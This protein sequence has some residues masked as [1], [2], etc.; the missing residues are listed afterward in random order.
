MRFKFFLVSVAL[1]AVGV[2]L[3]RMPHRQFGRSPKP[4]S[5]FGP[6]THG[7]PAGR[8]REVRTGVPGT[9]KDGLADYNVPDPLAGSGI[10]TRDEAA[11]RIYELL[12]GGG[13]ALPISHEDFIARAK[14]KLV[15]QNDEEYETEWGLFLEGVCFVA[16]TGRGCLP[17]KILYYGK[18]TEFPEIRGLPEEE[19]K[20]ALM[21]KIRVG[22]EEAI[23]L[24]ER[25]ISLRWPAFRAADFEAP[26]VS[27]GT[28]Y[29]KVT[30]DI[31]WKHVPFKSGAPNPTRLEVDVD[32]VTGQ[33]LE[34]E[35]KYLELDAEPI[36]QIDDSVAVDIARRKALEWVQKAGK[37]ERREILKVGP[38]ALQLVRRTWK[39]GDLRWLVHVDARS[40]DEKQSWDVRL[41]VYVDAQTG[42]AKVE[43]W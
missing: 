26:R 33:I 13:I 21:S 29:D 24:A 30:Y 42:A 15:F 17:I 25:F 12:T 7:D 8:T 11:R 36:P 1:V 41:R 39:T 14:E 6:F 40:H 37:H 9:G 2:A 16:I 23:A 3:W 18:A 28:F 20:A 38:W 35:G 22:E 19:R 5:N 31:R 43:W 4:N 10:L 34:F 32:A 27:F